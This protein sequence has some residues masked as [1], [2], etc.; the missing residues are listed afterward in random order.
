MR[1]YPNN[2]PDSAAA[3]IHSELG[4][5]SVKQ[6]VFT[7]YKYSKGIPLAE[8]IQLGNRNVFLQIEE[9]ELKISSEID[10][11]QEKNIVIKP[12]Q[13]SEITPTLTYPFQDEDDIRYVIQQAD[14]E[15]IHSL[16][17]KSISLWKSFVV[18]KDNDTIVFLAVDQMYSYFQDLFATTHYDMV[19]GS[20]GSGKGAI[21]GTMKALGYRVV[22]ASDMSGANLLDIC[23][24]FEP[25]QVTVAEDEFDDIERDEVKKKTYKV[26]YDINGIVPRTLDGNTSARGNRYYYAYCFK[27]FAAE[28]PLESKGLAGLNDRMFRI[29]SI[30]GRPKFLIKT[31][32]DQMQK[33]VDKQNPKY[34]TI[35]SKIV[36]LRKLLL[37]Y[38]LLHHGDI[39]KEVP[40]NIDGRAWELT[41]PQVF[42]FNSDKL[43]ASIEDKP[44]LE[45]VLRTLS[46]FL[47]KKGEITKMTVEGKVHEALER[48]LFP[49]I[50]ANTIIDLNGYNII[51]YTIS[52][53]S[54]CD[55]VRDLVDGV[56]ST[57]ANEYA[58]Y[59]TDYGRITHKRILKICRD[60]FSAVPDSVGAGNDKV[61]ALTFDKNIVEKVGKTFEII[62]EIKIVQDSNE[63]QG[64]GDSDKWDIP[65]HNRPTE[66]VQI[67]TQDKGNGTKG[68]K[69]SD[70]GKV[71]EKSSKEVFEE[72]V[73]K[74]ESIRTEGSNGN[75]ALSSENGSIFV[76]TS[77]C[78]SNQFK[79]YHLDCDFQTNSEREYQKHGTTRHPKNPL[80]YPSR[81]EIDKYGLKPQG[82]EWE[83]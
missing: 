50:T 74:R 22:L 3:K 4:S 63:D 24:P 53:E 46:R 12:H 37:I 25:C 6:K 38:R 40:L 49:F 5:Y 11:G 42:L 62:S 32:L 7:V 82:K 28:N 69:N 61:R 52:N 36:Y 43:A 76:P 17:S 71:K 58:F 26:G 39:I 21:L 47:Q 79:C 83:I 19:T 72:Y 31:I 29:E 66:N 13:R 2:D 60:R 30:K 80:L 23:G 75:A 67:H 81:F 59:S 55:K 77:Q 14:K 18:A 44:A 68:Q 65:S 54:V 51:T 15:T 48:E 27:M 9:G 16:L 35:I 73:S 41:S 64:E 33:P 78:T 56:Q 10:L 8:E 1:F 20:P 45:M 70:L 34:R 57:T